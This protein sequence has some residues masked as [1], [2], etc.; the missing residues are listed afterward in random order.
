MDFMEFLNTLTEAGTL[1]DE[2]RTQIEENYTF[3]SDLASEKVAGLETANGDAMANLARIEGERDE[4][5]AK[6]TALTEELAFTKSGKLDELLAGGANQG[7]VSDDDI[8]ADPDEVVS[9]T[10]DELAEKYSN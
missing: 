10:A 3:H 9:L 7:D 1:P 2:L 6:V 5:T 8:A 4:L